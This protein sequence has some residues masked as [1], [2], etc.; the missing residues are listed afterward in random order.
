R[1]A[2]E[3]TR[4]GERIGSAVR[5]ANRM[6]ELVE[7]LL[8]VSRIVTGRLMLQLGE[9]DLAAVVRE[10]AE[11]LRDHADIA[12]SPIRVDGPDAA[13]G[14]WDG[15]RLHQVV[16]NLVGNALKYGGGKP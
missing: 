1:G 6:T 3:P 9:C 10:V 13:A 14:L 5:Q 15:A 12:G 8:D 4:A 2:L 7:R 11:D 16:S